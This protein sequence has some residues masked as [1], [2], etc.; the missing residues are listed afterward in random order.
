MLRLL[1]PVSTLIPS[2]FSWLLI[3]NICDIN[4]FKKTLSSIVYFIVSVKLLSR[5]DLL[6]SFQSPDASN[7][8]STPA[9]TSANSAWPLNSAC[10]SPMSSRTSPSRNTKWTYTWTERTRSTTS[11]STAN[12]NTAVSVHY[13]IGLARLFW[14]WIFRQWLVFLGIELSLW[15]A[16]KKSMKYN[17][18]YFA[19]LVCFK[20]LSRQHLW[21]SG[22]R[23]KE[24]LWDVILNRLHYCGLQ[25]NDFV[26][27]SI[28]IKN[29]LF[30]RIPGR[31]RPHI[32]TKGYRIRVPRP[33]PD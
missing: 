7:I 24:K 31:H 9:S 32:P 27:S 13:F 11:T 5:F 8:S 28:T 6:F 20:I 10:R 1:P 25:Q 4:F 18:N 12:L 3:V 15:I 26:R 2:S 23:V 29:I 16:F 22:I 17:Q 30:S 33:V 14:F 19:C 21:C